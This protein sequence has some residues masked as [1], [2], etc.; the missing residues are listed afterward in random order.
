MHEFTFKWYGNIWN[1]LFYSQRIWIG[2]YIE[3]ADLVYCNK[4]LLDVL[5]CMSNPILLPWQ[6]TW[7]KPVM[8]F[9][10]YKINGASSA[11]SSKHWQPRTGGSVSWASGC[12]A[13]GRELSH[14]ACNCSGGRY[15]HCPTLGKVEN[16]KRERARTAIS[17]ALIRHSL[18]SNYANHN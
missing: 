3:L 18:F 1:K 14:T 2:Y 8:Y 15:S 13:G 6:H 4:S 17:S 16:K 11:W 9:H 5:L 10:I 7:S 12:Y